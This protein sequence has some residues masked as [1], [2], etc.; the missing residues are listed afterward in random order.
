MSPVGHPTPAARVGG[1]AGSPRCRFPFSARFGCGGVSVGGFDFC[2]EL[3]ADLGSQKCWSRGIRGE[4]GSGSG[5]G[6]ACADGRVW[7][8]STASTCW[9]GERARLQVWWLPTCLPGGLPACLPACLPGSQAVWLA[10]ASLPYII[11]PSRTSQLRSL[12]CGGGWWG[13]TWSEGERCGAGRPSWAYQSFFLDS[14]VTLCTECTICRFRSTSV[15]QSSDDED[16]LLS[17]QESTPALVDCNLAVPKSFPTA[18]HFGVIGHAS[19][20]RCMMI[21]VPIAGV[22]NTIQIL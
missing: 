19:C 16:M 6:A 21:V 22:G 12:N 18:S 13:G 17:L 8:L 4:E 11:F 7:V 5:R 1:A 2:C 14:G 15:V 10:A 3:R 9:A 20:V